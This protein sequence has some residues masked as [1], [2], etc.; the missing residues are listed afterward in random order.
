MIDAAR[1]RAR[2]GHL[3]RDKSDTLLLI[4]AALMVLAPHAAHLPLW[5]SATVCVTLLWRAAITWRGKRM[6]PLWLLLP[7]SLLAMG[8]VFLSY[9]TLLGRDAGVAM[10]ALLLAFKLLEMR[11]R[12]DLFVVIF[13]SFFLLLTNFFYTQSIATAAA[14]V[15]TIVALLTALQTF[16]YSGV[17]P[18]LAQRVRAAGKLAL[19]AAPLALLLFVAFPRIQ[20]PLWGLPGDANSA[21]SGMSDSMAPGTVSSLALSEEVAFRVRFDGAAPAQHQ[22]YWRG[23]VL[24]EYDGTTWTRGGRALQRRGADAPPISIRLG[25][26]PL[27]YALTLEPTGQ[28]WLFLLEYT[29]PNIRFAG[30]RAGQSDQLETYALQPLQRRLRYDGAAYLQYALQAD[31]DAQQMAA[32]LRLPDGYNPRALALAATLRARHATAQ[33]RSQAVLDLFASQGYAYTLEPPLLGRDAVDDFLFT[34]QAG[35]CEH[36]ASAYVVLMRAAGVPARVVTGYQGGEA[37]PVDGY[38]TVRQS[39]AHAWAEIWV[40]GAGW[41]R[42][43]P[44]A[45]V[46]PDRVARNLAR[47]LPRTSPFG[48][49]GLGELMAD[50]DSWLAQLRFNVNALNNAWNQ[51][52][53]DYNPDR[54]RSFLQELVGVLGNWR[55]AA[56]VLAI[57]AVLLAA[58]A[59]RQRQAR[60][61]LDAAYAQFC[62]RMG[63]RGMPRLPHEGPH[64]YALRLRAL[65]APTETKAAMAAFLDLYGALKYGAP[66][67]NDS[68]QSLKRLATLLKQ[69]R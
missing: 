4:V 17:V 26:A 53:L 12:R 63:R 43:D 69:S 33:A 46:A 29:E 42:V 60:D 39:D 28:R 24:T 57:A 66:A 54:Q 7:I 10:L 41:L 47:A 52:V 16:Q 3:T 59:V 45:A 35:F 49:A 48:F 58:R 67:N 31:A 38:L 20:G 50:R 25:G 56:A 68:A 61:P 37:N 14:M 1:W 18:P 62:A 65:A 19:L 27:R 13:L 30:I 22:L 36:Y 32:W 5:T 40:A 21:R 11:A 34:T 23:I 44:T 9:R 6:P 8:G 64:S 15:A 2:F 51:W 55:S